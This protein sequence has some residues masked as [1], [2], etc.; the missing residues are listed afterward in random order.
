MMRMQNRRDR[1]SKALT[2]LFMGLAMSFVVHGQAVDRPNILFIAVD[3]LNCDFGAYGN[4]VVQSPSLDQIAAEG[5]LFSNNHCQKAVCGPSRASLLSGFTPE[6]T[7]ITGFRQYLRDLYPDVVTL[8][9]FFKNNG[10]FTA[11]MGKIHDYRNVSLTDEVDLISWSHWVDVSGN[12]YAVSAGK[13]VTEA[14]DVDD[15]GYIDGNIADAGVDQIRS[16]AAGDQPFFLAVGFKKP[17]LPFAAPKKYWDLYDRDSISLAAYR[18]FAEN[19]QE[20]VHNPGAEFRGNYDNVPEEGEFPYELQ[21]EYIHGYYACVSYI[22]AQIGK[23]LRELKA[24]GLYDNTI[25]VVWGDHGFSLGDHTNWGKHTNFEYATRSPLIIKTPGGV[26]GKVIQSPSEL[27]DIYPTLVDL[28]GFQVPDTLD[29]NSLKP[30]LTGEHDRVKSF[31]VSQFTRGG[32]QGFA[33]R[34]AYYQYVRW[35]DDGQVAHQQ[36]FNFAADPYQTKNLYANPAYSEIIDTFSFRLDRYLQEG[37]NREPILLTANTDSLGTYRTEKMLEFSIYGK[38]GNVTRPLKGADI[39]IGVLDLPASNAGYAAINLQ[40]STYSY[41]ITLENYDTINGTIDLKRDTLIIDTLE[42]RLYTLTLRAIDKYSGKFLTG[43]PIG[44][45]NQEGVTD[46]KGE[47]SFGLSAETY[48]ITVNA[49]GYSR[50]EVDYTVVADTLVELSLEPAFS[51]VKFRLKE[52][53]IPVYYASVTVS[54]T[55]SMLSN[56]IGI[57]QFID[58]PVK[59][60]YQY[61]VQKDGYIT[62]EDTFYLRTDTTL[63]LEMAP[64]THS[65]AFEVSEMQ[66]QVFLAGA[67]IMLGDSNMMTGDDGKA[68]FYHM[69]EDTYDYTV[70]LDSYEDHH[71]SLELR[72]DTTLKVALLA[73]ATINAMK[74]D[75]LTLYPNPSNRYVRLDFN[76]EIEALTIYSEGGRVLKQYLSPPEH[77]QID[78]Q[79]FRSGVYFISFKLPGIKKQMIK[80]VIKR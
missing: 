66:K 79:E 75:G 28:A 43:I 35:A 80:K 70:S 62:L 19:D 10:Y 78:M 76:R 65:V 14:A 40:P 36:L 46:Y 51:D 29:G 47:V 20:F 7:G 33:L 60:L 32:N 54:D 22:D 30:I 42:R 58:L 67:S 50:V 45:G 24:Q 48:R 59:T 49:E 72:N 15:N 39:K 16:L 9:Q 25:I 63:A 1:V 4:R 41:S 31:A 74:E 6:H 68:I 18:Q 52:N 57:A 2:S 8:P 61:K 38:D 53:G 37:E 17:H 56:A 3:D 13:P 27:L 12:R 77:G 5:V 44:V 69:R 34:A 73:T 71:G 26:A 55:L 21:R 23:L 64:A 11:G